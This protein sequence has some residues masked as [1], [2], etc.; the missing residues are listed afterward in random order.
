MYDGT[1]KVLGPVQTKSA[2]LNSCQWILIHWL[3]TT[4]R[5]RWN[6][7]LTS[8]WNRTLC[9]RQPSM[10]SNAC[11]P[12]MNWILNQCWVSTTR[13]LSLATGILWNTS[14]LYQAMQDN[15]TAPIAWSPL[16]M[17]A[18]GCFTTAHEGR[19]DH[20]STK[21][22]SKEATASTKEESLFSA[23]LAKHT[24]ES[25]SFDYR[26]LQ[27]GFRANRSTVEMIFSL[28]SCTSHLSISRRLSTWLTEGVYSRSC[29]T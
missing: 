17:L 20:S 13:P 8:N 7:I 25:V 23:L 12:R 18:S 19:H 10:I 4:V 15:P 27:Y 3:E 1:K 5:N 11:Q 9:L 28:R 16:P 6:I 14:R 21:A 2:H 24:H 26:N 22:R 29:L